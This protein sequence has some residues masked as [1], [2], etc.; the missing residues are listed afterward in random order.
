VDTALNQKLEKIVD[1]RAAFTS[2]NLGFNL[3]IARIQKTYA[4]NRT[5]AEMSG[6]VRELNSFLEKYGS[7]MK[8]E[9][10][11]IKNI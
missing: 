2:H 1:G 9:I 5:P 10:A 4:A 8:D 3:L 7:I 11:A 6:C